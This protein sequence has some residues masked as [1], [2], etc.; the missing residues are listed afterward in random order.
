VKIS[1]LQFFNENRIINISIVASVLSNLISN[2]PAV[3]MLSPLIKGMINP[4]KIWL[5]LALSSTFAGNLTLLGSVANLIVVEM[6]RKRGVN[7]KF[8]EYLKSGVIITLLSLILGI[9]W[10]MFI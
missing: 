5:T 4:E 7:V 10:L 9:L 6:A 1:D 2:V 8:V 3:L